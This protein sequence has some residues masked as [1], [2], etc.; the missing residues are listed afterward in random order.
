MDTYWR[1]IEPL[2]SCSGRRRSRPDS[3]GQ[4]YGGT[5]APLIVDDMII[6]GVSGADEGIRGF[7]SQPLN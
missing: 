1:L 4:H 6:T 2:G 5:I 3:E 7:R